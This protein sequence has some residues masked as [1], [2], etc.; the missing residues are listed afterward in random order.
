[1]WYEE[2]EP[3]WIWVKLERFYHCRTL[4]HNREN[5]RMVEVQ[6]EIPEESLRIRKK[7]G[8]QIHE[9]IW[10]NTSI[11][12]PNY[13]HALCVRL[14]ELSDEAFAKT[15]KKIRAREERKRLKK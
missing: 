8:H 2:P 10:V 6:N 7:R 15:E 13:E 11:N 3:L 9:T 1:M 14:A 4:P 5:F 12:F